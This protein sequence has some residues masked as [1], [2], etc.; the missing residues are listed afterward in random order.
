M[1][2]PL[3]GLATILSF[4]AV[5]EWM[6]GRSSVRSDRSRLERASARLGRSFGLLEARAAPLESRLRAAG[7]SRISSG[8]VLAVKS[9]LAAAA[10]PL[11][12]SVAPA[13]PGRAPL[14]L[15]PLLV[16]GA[17]FAPNLLLVRLARRRREELRA[18][19]PAVLDLMATAAEAG[20]GI[21][22]L[23]EIGVKGSRGPLQ[24]ELARLIAA[25]DCGDSQ[26]AALDRLRAEG[27][28]LAQLAVTMQ[29]SR[30]LGSPLAVGLRAQAS[31]LREGEQRSIAERGAKAAPKIQLVVALILVPSVLLMVAAAIAAHSD[32]IVGGL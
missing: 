30:R 24:Q 3:A 27:G 15:I 4:V 22:G 26:Q 6:A 1:T 10:V 9:L 18:E 25:I 28:D 7:L 16:A 11:A 21:P 23:L 5:Y 12:I 17:F 19:L 32:S 8:V 20:R 14:L 2:A 29:R 31:S 13:A